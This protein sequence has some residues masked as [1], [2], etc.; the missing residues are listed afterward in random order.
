M[1]QTKRK[2]RSKH[3]GNAA[4]MVEARGRTGRKPTPDERAP[5]TTKG[6]KRKVDPRDKPPTWQGSLQRAAIAS[7]LLFVLALALLGQTV[8]QA[9]LVS[10]LSLALYVPLGYQV[11]KVL[12]ERRQKKKAAGKR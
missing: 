9:A 4:G 6:A 8:G 7:A 12:Y 1:A 5:K 11:D 3:R 2:R 10:L